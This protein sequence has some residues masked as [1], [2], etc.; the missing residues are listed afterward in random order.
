MCFCSLNNESLLILSLFLILKGILL[1]LVSHR[2]DIIY[3]RYNSHFNN[4]TSFKPWSQ[5]FSLFRDLDFFH[6]YFLFNWRC[7][8]LFF[9][10]SNSFLQA[11]N[12][13]CFFVPLII[14]HHCFIVF[15]HQWQTCGNRNQE[16]N[17]IY[18]NHCT[19]NIILFNT[20]IL[21]K[22]L[23]QLKK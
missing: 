20:I 12:M 10:T 6:H 23:V 5:D 3:F 7:G 8:S 13:F 18:N 21:A 9:L 2:P 11:R 16:R 4:I 1:A 22:I 14:F 17:H 15:T 19:S